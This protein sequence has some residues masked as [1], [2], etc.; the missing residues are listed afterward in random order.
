MALNNI[1]GFDR[2]LRII[3]GVVLV[4]LAAMGTIGWWGWIGLVLILSG[5]TSTC[6]IY[7]VL[8][9]NTAKKS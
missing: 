8:G 5:V 6:F 7:K 1:G 2:L 9:I 4:V 3:L